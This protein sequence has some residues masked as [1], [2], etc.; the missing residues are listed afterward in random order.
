MGKS[1][2]ILV[3]LA[4]MVSFGSCAQKRPITHDPVVA[5][6][7]D[8]YYLFCTGPGITSFTSKDLKNWTQQDPVFPESPEWALEVAPGFNGHIWAPDI[9]LYNGTYYLYYS[10]SAFGKNTSAIGLVTNATLN[11]DDDNYKW[12]DQGIVIQSVPNRDL[13]NAIDPNLIFD[14]NGTPWMAFG[15]FWSGLKMVKMNANLKEVAQ[16]EEWHTIARRDRDAGLADDDPGNAALE[17]PFIFKK[18]DYYYQFLSWDFCC[19]GEES[20]YKLMVGR[21]KS[22]TGPYLD[23]EGKRLDEGGGSMVIEGNKNW[24]GV[25]HNSVFTFDGKDY[26]FMHG[27]D[28]SDNGLPKLIV[29]EVSWEDGWPVVAPMN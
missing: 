22:V 25:G 12:E 26:N 11:P 20:T 19:R 2:S 24:Y 27:Y 13:W 29:K 23:K 14:E 5:K 3:M 7:G 4:L 17:G 9:T 8:T 18:G 1:T 10:I 28:A 21:S 6:Q 15:S 16:P